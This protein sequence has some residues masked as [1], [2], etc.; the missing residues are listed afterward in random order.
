MPI[1]T[2]T[3]FV[4]GVTELVLDP[5]EVAENRV[6]LQLNTGP[7]RVAQDGPDWGDGA[8]AAYKAEHERGETV[9]DYRVPNRTITIPLVLGADGPDNFDTARAYLMSKVARLQDEG[10]WL[11]R[12]DVDTGRYA[13]I[14][15]ASLRLPDRY[16]H[17]RAEVDVVLVLEAI[18][19]FYGDEIELDLVTETT[20]PELVALLEDIQGDHPGRVRVEVTDLSGNAQLGLLGAFRCRHYSADATARLAY[21]A[22]DLE[23]LDAAA[24]VGST[25]E[26]SDLSTNWT[27]VLGTNIGGT[28]WMTHVGSYGVW[29]RVESDDGDDVQIRWVYDVGDL[30]LPEENTRVVIPGPENTYLLYL[31]DMRLDPPPVGT[32]RWQGQLQAKGAAGGEHVA[33]HRLYFQP[34]GESAVKLR[35]PAR[36]TD[37]LVDLSVRD[38]FRQGVGPLTGELLQIPAEAW[39]EA[40]DPDGFDITADGTVTRTSVSDASAHFAIAGTT[41]YA[42]IAV[43]VDVKADDWSTSG[44]DALAAGLF[45]R[46]VST[47]SRLRAVIFTDSASPDDNAHLHVNALGGSLLPRRYPLPFTLA[48]DTFYTIRLVAEVGGRFW[49]W[50]WPSDSIPLE[51]VAVGA[52]DDYAVGGANESG[53][54]GL[55]DHWTGAGARTRTYRRLR[56][57]VPNL[58]AVIHPNQSAELRTEGFFREDAGGVGVGP[59]SDPSGSDLPRIPVSGLEGRPVELLALTSTGDLDQLPDGDPADKSVLVHYRPSYLFPQS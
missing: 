53:N 4:P 18:P 34:L 24:V 49:V 5:A 14:V 59:V 29:V 52:H 32:H 47:S 19:D 35:A 20:N 48:D 26:H 54:L 10:G 23:P 44:S 40:G 58:D 51:P 41:D 13:D 7:I 16:G 6:E 8:I 27:P 57:W 21:A 25:V 39:G 2:G 30:V 31:G 50:V 46:Y 1:V 12:G 28:D 22:T 36:A 9:V 55:Y 45:A 38:D 37:G 42:A 15:D 3:E 43:Q 33:A 11:K 17:Q 56:A